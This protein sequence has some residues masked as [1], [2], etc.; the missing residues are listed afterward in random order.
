MKCLPDILPALFSVA[1][2]I[3]SN[4]WRKFKLQSA[5]RILCVSITKMPFPRFYCSSSNKSFYSWKNFIIQWKCTWAAESEHYLQLLPPAA[6]RRVL[7]EE[8]RH[9]GSR[10][11]PLHFIEH[12]GSSPCSQQRAAG[13]LMSPTTPSCSFPRSTL[14]SSAHLCLGL[15]SSLL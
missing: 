1:L 9:Q 12:E 7:L 4:C 13:P 3:S 14:I 10:E 8:Q 5:K 6:W 2:R 15:S 11:I